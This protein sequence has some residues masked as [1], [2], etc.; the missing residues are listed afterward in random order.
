MPVEVEVE[1]PPQGPAGTG[2]ATL[3]AVVEG[4]VTGVVGGALVGW[5]AADADAGGYVEALAEGEGCF[6]RA[7]AGTPVEGRAPFSVPIPESFND[8]QIRFLDV[9][10]MGSDRP[11]AGGPVIHDGGLF[12]HPTPAQLPAEEPQPEAMTVEGQVEFTGPNVLRGWAWAPDTPG[13]RLRLEILA[14]DRFIAAITAD[15][16]REDLAAQGLGD[17]RY[18]FQVDLARLLRRGPHRVIV[19]VA[20]SVHALPG[21]DVLAG[22]F[23]ADGEVDCPGYL[24]DEASRALASSLPFEHLAFNARRIAPTRLAPRLLNRLRRERLGFAGRDPAPVLLLRLS[25]VGG[26]ASEVWSL[27]SHPRTV[28]AAASEGADAIRNAA[29]RAGFV[30]F[31]RDGDL[32]HPSA[33]AI[34]ASLEGADVLTWARFSADEHRPG[35]AGWVARRPPFDPATVRHGAVTDTTLAVRGA[36]LAAA[37]DDVLDALAADR[38]HPLWF[39]LAGCTDAWRN[40]AEALTSNVGEAPLLGRGEVEADETIYR[41]LLAAEGSRFSLESTRAE[42]PFPFAL[43]PSRRAGVISALIPFRDRAALTLRCLN[44]LSRQRIS[45][46]LQIVLV[47]NQSRPEE[48]AAVADGARRMF[49]EA[50][51]ILLAW[52]APFSH[53]AQNNLAA[54]AAAGEVILICNNDV[55]PDDPDTLEQLAAWALEPGVGT[56]GCRLQD[57]ERN[58]GSYGQAFAEPSGDPFQPPMRE[59]PDP[60][61]SEWVHACPGST[62]AFAAISRE[63]FLDLGGL[64]EDRFPIGYNDIDFALRCR[65][66]G[67]VNL[68]LGH[69]AA[70]HVRGS[71]RS[72]DNE[73][74]QALWL[75]LHHPSAALGWMQ[76]L[77]RQ[78]IETARAEVKGDLPGRSPA[79]PAVVDAAGSGALQDVVE[80]RRELERRRARLAE[81]LVRAS[82]QAGKL[83]DELRVLKS[84]GS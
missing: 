77:S 54:R 42:F 20:G 37:P 52:D 68:Y 31:A 76:Q 62:M 74:L 59:N 39:W 84:L 65:Q 58:I 32:L 40:H 50:R 30:F 16:P 57:P 60:R 38:L 4:R 46:E 13:R 22:P 63:R 80:A 5:I 9:R 75:N 12:E 64:D 35:S 79:G 34:A 44:A 24:D 83:G 2:E 48:A 21:G 78:R 49:G 43:S 73:D 15:Q 27:Q 14:N 8:G 53:S 17:A 51:V 26:E 81:A 6:G 36:V 72:G 3:D 45:G 19:R 7:S 10:P 47:D 25:G 61:W 23:A 1:V 69:L 67:L 28:V 55:A 29:L 71:S 41:R 18:G 82:D 70:R 66:A 33:G 11:L 56:V